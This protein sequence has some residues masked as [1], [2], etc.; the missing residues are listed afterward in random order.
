M[1]PEMTPRT[2][3]A[4]SRGMA[5]DMLEGTRLARRAAGFIRRL[6]AGM[7][8]RGRVRVNLL[9]GQAVSLDGPDRA[10]VECLEGAVWAT[11]PTDGRDLRIRAGE[12]V[13]FAWPGQVVL[14][15]A[16]RPA[17][18]VLRWR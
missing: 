14:A 11:C 13:S 8:P 7:A 15:A 16:N 10:L 1:A 6:L 17:R 4:E 18:V 2:W 3:P 9:P 12:S 5:D